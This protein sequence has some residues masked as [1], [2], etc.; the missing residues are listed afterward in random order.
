MTTKEKCLLI[1]FKFILLKEK[2]TD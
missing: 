2:N 1:N